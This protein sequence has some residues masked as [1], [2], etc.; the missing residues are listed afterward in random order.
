MDSVLQD[1]DV[2][3]Y[4]RFYSAEKIPDLTGKVAVV[5]GGSSGIGAE[6]C[7]QLA[8]HGAKV[9][10]LSRGEAQAQGVI[11]EIKNTHPSAQLEY[12]KL[13]LES[14]A[15]SIESAKLLMEKTDRID[16]VHLNAGLV[17]T[18]L[19]STTDG[20]EPTVGIQHLGHFAFIMTLLPFL[21]KQTLDDVRIVVTASRN[22]S[23]VA[24]GIDFTKLGPSKQKDL[25]DAMA[26]YAQAKLCNVLMS[27]Y[28][29]KLLKNRGVTNVT[30]NSHDP[31]VIVT[32]LMNPIARELGCFAGVFLA[33]YRLIGISPQQGALTGL[34]VSTSPDA[35][36]ISGEYYIPIG[37]RAKCAKLAQDEA[38][39][40]KLWE[41]SE[42]QMARTSS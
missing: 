20:I 24:K 31:G 42:A 15:E 32:N 1:I 6:I 29:A 30:I 19:E 8:T 25:D 27:N 10:I 14:I 4:K 39:Q 3:P 7:R 12:H 26:K 22:H 36:G 40:K 5:T 37:Q 41:W 13:N 16:I 21:E 34:F 9:Y 28:L 11:A 2:L 38:L 18:S 23:L 35:K 33:L 17:M